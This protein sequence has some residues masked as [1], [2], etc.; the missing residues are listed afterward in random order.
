MGRT[1]QFR[2]ARPGVYP[3]PSPNCKSSFNWKGNLNRHLKYE[4]GLQPRF[5]CPYCHYCCKVKGDVRK[6]IARKHQG[7]TV[8]VV[9]L[10]LTLSPKPTC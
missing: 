10:F 3:C 9:D 4:C 1:S 5:K 8:F 2:R 7:S 6:H